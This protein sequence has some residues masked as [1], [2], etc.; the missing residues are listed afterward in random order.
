MLVEAGAN[1]EARDDD[2]KTRLHHAT[3]RLNLGALLALLKHG[4]HV[5]A[6]IGTLGPP[7]HYAA[8]KAGA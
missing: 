8:A 1:N 3:G 5:D 2:S 7:L 4:A 6:Q